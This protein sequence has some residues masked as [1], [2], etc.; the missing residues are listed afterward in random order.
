MHTYNYDTY[1][2][3]TYTYKQAQTR[4][5]TH[6]RTRTHART[7]THKHTQTHTLHTYTEKHTYIHARTHT[8]TGRSATAADLPPEQRALKSATSSA[9][10]C[11]ATL[12]SLPARGL[13]HA[14]SML[15]SCCFQCWH[16]S[17]CCAVVRHHRKSRHS[18]AAATRQGKEVLNFS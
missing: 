8:H 2:T 4:R 12:P 5:C 1:T 16:K 9:E 6:I 11:T 3:R 7:H 10:R 13:L 18:L 15:V 17:G 14:H